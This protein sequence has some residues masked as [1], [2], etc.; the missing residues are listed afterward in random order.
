MA[1]ISSEN[2]RNSLRNFNATKRPKFCF[3]QAVFP[4]FKTEISFKFSRRKFARA[5][6]VWLE[7]V[8]NMRHFMDR[9]L[10]SFSHHPSQF[11]PFISSTYKMS[12]VALKCQ[13]PAFTHF[14]RA[15][16]V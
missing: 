9:T 10:L 11:Q 8:H 12:N 3:A 14:A 16:L 4:L 1:T 7:V 15:K 6:G 5:K 2:L 13:K